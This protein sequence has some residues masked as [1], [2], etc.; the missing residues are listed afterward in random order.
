MSIETVLAL[1]VVV[2]HF[3]VLVWL[4]AR[5][6]RRRDVLRAQQMSNAI[7]QDYRQPE[8]RRRVRTR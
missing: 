3:V 1:V 8:R 6:W 5:I 4:G 7:M 2:L